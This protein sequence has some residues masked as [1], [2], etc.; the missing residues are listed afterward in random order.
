METN[1]NGNFYSYKKYLSWD[2]KKGVLENPSNTRMI[3]FPN[4]FMVG[5]LEGLEDECGQA[6]SVVMYRCGEWWGKRQMQRM[7]RNLG[8]HF[9]KSLQELPTAQVHATFMEG[10]ATEGW[11]R[12]KLDLDNLQ[13][14]F[15]YASVSNSPITEAFLNSELD[16]RK[17][18]VDFLTTG[19][20]VGMFSQASDTELIG[21]QI[22]CITQGAERN[23]FLVGQKEVLED[24]QNMV[25]KGMSAAEIL[26]T[27]TQA[28]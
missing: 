4:C 9:G 17:R 2:M 10:W 3:A 13:H 20:L 11:G 27:L 5:L 24:V 15:I 8:E 12:L 22:A 19:A 26:S 1:F 23:E 18:P 16:A 21:C 28:H 6:W 14:G 25:K 7:E